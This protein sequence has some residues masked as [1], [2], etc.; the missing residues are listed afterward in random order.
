[1]ETNREHELLVIEERRGSKG[2]NTKFTEARQRVIVESL[3]RGASIRL[4]ATSAAISENCLR[5]WIREG[6]DDWEKDDFDTNPTDKATFAKAC[7]LATWEVAHN[8]LQNIEAN[9]IAD[10]R[11]SAWLLERRFP[12]DY[13]KQVVELEGEVAAK[14]LN[15]EKV[16]DI[17]KQMADYE[18]EQLR[19]DLGAVPAGSN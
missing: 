13:G 6:E 5:K 11:A 19:V 12:K 15:P 8:H 3:R 9:A 16:A 17:F 4:A 2:N 1:M 14:I 10:W 7:A 18:A